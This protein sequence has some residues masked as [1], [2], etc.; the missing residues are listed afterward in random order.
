MDQAARQ[1]R[2]VMEYESEAFRALFPNLM[3]LEGGTESGFRS[4][5]D[6]DLHAYVAR[7]LQVKKYGSSTVVVEV[8]CKRDS[9]NHGDAFVLD[10][11]DTLY[12]WSGNQSTSFERAFARMAAEEL[13]RA[14][15]GKAVATSTIDNGFWETLGGYGPIKSRA[16]A[17]EALPQPVALGDGVLYKLSDKTGQLYLTE[18][19]RG[20]LN[21]E[22]LLPQDVYICDPG[23]EVIVW[24]GESANDRERRAAM[25][26]ATKYLALQGK[27]HSTPIKV[28]KS[29]ADAMTDSSFAQIFAGTDTAYA[30]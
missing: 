18:V 28:F 1:H 15:A 9:L 22:M 19:H 27:P 23:T 8:P 20:A 7:L 6:I 29:T 3:Y 21:V 25:L 2:E 13:E 24:V 26:T 4:V 16:D 5:C 14:R 10:K 11:G 17:G 30:C 12:A